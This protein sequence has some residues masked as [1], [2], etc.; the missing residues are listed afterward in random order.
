M[1][2]VLINASKKGLEWGNKV[3]DAQFKRYFDVLNINAPFS[4]EWDDIRGWIK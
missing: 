4:F 2:L 1:F 3:L